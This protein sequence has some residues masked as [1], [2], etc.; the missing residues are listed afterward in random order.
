[1]RRKSPMPPG[2]CQ[3]FYMGEADNI[4]DP[5]EATIEEYSAYFFG[6]N[7]FGVV[8]DACC[9]VENDSGQEVDAISGVCV[10][11]IAAVNRAT[12]DRGHWR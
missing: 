5:L 10:E 9:C 7:A 4:E 6:E 3:A 2:A 11:E 1:M 12:G 8:D